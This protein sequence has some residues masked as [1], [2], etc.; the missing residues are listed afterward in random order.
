MKSPNKL[1]KAYAK[2]GLAIAQELAF[3]APTDKEFRE[4]TESQWAEVDRMVLTSEDI[5]SIADMN[6]EDL[7]DLGCNI[8]LTKEGKRIAELPS[9]I[10]RLA[11]SDTIYD[12]GTIE[13]DDEEFGKREF[14]ITGV[15]LN[16][17]NAFE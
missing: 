4:F 9:H 16:G 13:L 8:L 15:F 5:K 11:E 17:E 7:K 6:D 1:Y 2:L 10:R 3:S 12:V 14:K